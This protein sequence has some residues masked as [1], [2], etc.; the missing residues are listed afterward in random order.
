MF[1]LFKKKE[2]ELPEFNVLKNSAK[3]EMYFFRLAQ[4][5]WLDDKNIHVVDNNA[6]RMITMDPWPQMIYLDA[7]GQKTVEEYILELAGKY[8]HKQ[9]IP[10]ELDKEVIDLIDDLASDQLIGLSNTKQTLPYYIDL[11]KGK[12]DLEKAKKLI[13]KD[14]FIKE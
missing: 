7:D 12:Q 6:P 14:G 9:T 3:K 8:G 11:P 1:G 10:Q 5:D 2:K 13:L 4:W